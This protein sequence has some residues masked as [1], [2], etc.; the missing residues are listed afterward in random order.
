[1]AHLGHRIASRIELPLGVFVEGPARRSQLSV[2]QR[3]GREEQRVGI[4]APAT[5]LDQR[6]V[7]DVAVLDRVR[8][9]TA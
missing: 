7:G 5:E 2:A 8:V 9:A 4:V 6:V 1:M 3:Q